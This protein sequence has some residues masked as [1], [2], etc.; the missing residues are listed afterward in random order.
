MLIFEMLK[1]NLL[2]F[3]PSLSFFFFFLLLNINWESMVHL[4]AKRWNRR[5]WFAS[6]RNRG[7]FLILFTCRAFSSPLEFYVLRLWVVQHPP[8]L[9]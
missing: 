4:S 6:G 8:A 5:A 7:A 9:V 3:P 2:I 1:G